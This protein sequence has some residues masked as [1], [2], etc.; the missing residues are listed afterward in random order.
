MRPDMFGRPVSLLTG[1]D[2]RRRSAG[3]IRLATP[4]IPLRSMPA[5][6]RSMEK[7]SRK[8]PESPVS[9]LQTKPHLHIRNE[10]PLRRSST[11]LREKRSFSLSVPIEQRHRSMVESSQ[12][13]G[14]G[15]RSVWKR[16]SY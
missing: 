6:L 12:A 15:E 8:R 10:A 13:L 4:R 9:L 11:R 14:C 7:S 3:S 16:D 5:G 1:L 2:T